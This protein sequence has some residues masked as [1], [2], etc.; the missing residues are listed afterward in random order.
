[1]HQIWLC[2]DNWVLGLSL[3]FIYITV[4][5]FI[6][7]DASLHFNADDL[8]IYCCE[9]TLIKA[10]ESL[11]NFHPTLIP[12]GEI[13]SQCRLGLNWDF[14]KYFV[15]TQFLLNAVSKTCS[16]WVRL[17]GPKL[18]LFSNSRK[19]PPIVPSVTTLEGHD[20]EV[21][22]M[23]QDHNWRRPHFLS[24]YRNACDEAKDETGFLF[25]K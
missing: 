6:V 19:R 25:L 4:L 13:C 16:T 15:W 3:F 18:M 2:C 17:N 21:V 24:A 23:S 12:S 10:I 11:L 5:G 7:N 8:I 14:C 1:M 20:M 22:H 9:W